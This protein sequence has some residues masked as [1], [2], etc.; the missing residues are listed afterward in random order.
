MRDDKTYPDCKSP[1]QARAVFNL[2]ANL[3]KH[4]TANRSGSS[5]TDRVIA[6][7]FAPFR[8]WLASVAKAAETPWPASTAFALAEAVPATKASCSRASVFAA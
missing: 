6:H 1:A 5:H 8:N 3:T 7:P 4:V 2:L